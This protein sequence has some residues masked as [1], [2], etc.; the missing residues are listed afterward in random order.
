MMKKTVFRAVVLLLLQGCSGGDSAPSNPEDTTA[1]EFTSSS[2]VNVAEN[3]T[4]AITL[5]AD[6]ES[7]VTYSIS[8]TDADSFTVDADSGVVTFK[9][10]PNF[11]EK[12]SYSFTAKATDS[13]N[14]SATQDITISIT[15]VVEPFI[16]VWETN[17]TDCNIT[18][19]TDSNYAYDYTIDWGDGDIEEGVT[20]DA[21][22]I[23]SSEGNWTVKISGEFPHMRMISS[24][25][26]AQE[27]IDNAHQLL[28][29]TAWGDIKW[30]DMTWMFAKC[31]QFNIEASDKPILKD[32]EKMWDMFYFAKSMNAPI[33][34]W[35]VSNVKYMTDMFNEANSFNQ[36]IGDWNV[37]N[38]IDMDMMFYNATAFNQNISK[39]DVS[40]VTD[41]M[42]MFCGTSFNQDI[43]DWNV[44]NV[45]DMYGMFGD[46][47]SFNQ[48][49]SDWD[50]S[51]VTTMAY[52]FYNAT[53][54]KD[55]DL[56]SWDVANV[57][58]HTDFATGSG[59]NIIEPNWP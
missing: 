6:D 21:T 36:P 29:V 19:S 46:T 12:D 59:G 40:K 2:N 49:I 44:S 45:T 25:P 1:P 39:W 54:F 31:D 8:G 33:G 50:T 18:I 43:S 22:H 55:Q 32:V 30:K 28:K 17:S 3:Q 51:S 23:Y 13:A 4:R 52:M 42:L 5:H 11:E 48:D 41:M 7:I 16:T 56:S 14:N 10:A 27:E 24:I 57:T 53:A 35:N 37:S 34:D 26:S 47:P 58:D 15:D 9:I 38:V 20:G